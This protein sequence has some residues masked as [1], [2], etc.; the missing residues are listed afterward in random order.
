MAPASRRRSGKHAYHIYGVRLESA[1]PL[2]WPKDAAP[3]LADISL[4]K[5]SAGRF[6]RALERVAVP[7]DAERW[8]T[9][10]AA[11]GTTYLRWSGLFEFLIAPDGRR[12]FCHP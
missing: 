7:P 5:G 9:A 1:W 11:G 4:M 8:V 10:A 12:M 6:D 3:W 2:P